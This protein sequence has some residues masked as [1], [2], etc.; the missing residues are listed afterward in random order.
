[1]SDTNDKA[2][3]AGEP[4][5]TSAPQQQGLDQ[6]RRL[7]ELL[8]I[9]EAQRSDAVWDEIIELEIQLAP[10]NRIG[11]GQGNKSPGSLPSKNPGT[12]GGGGGWKR[13]GTGRKHPKGGAGGKKPGGGGSQSAG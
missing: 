5:P 13:H 8:S 3:D 6:R 1:M 11:G 4:Q 10:G 2:Q 7:R 9:P 12:P